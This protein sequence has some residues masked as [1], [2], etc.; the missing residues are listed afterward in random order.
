VRRRFAPPHTIWVLICPDTDGYSYKNTKWRN[1][2][3]FWYNKLD[4][5]HSR[6]FAWLNTDSLLVIN[7]WCFAPKINH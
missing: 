5:S 1:H 6:N 3:V 7:F 4:Y 2:F